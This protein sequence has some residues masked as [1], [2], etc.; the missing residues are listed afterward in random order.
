MLQIIVVKDDELHSIEAF[1]LEF[2]YHLTKRLSSGRYVVKGGCN[3]RFFFASA[4]FSEDIEIDADTSIRKEALEA[5]VRKILSSPSFVLA[6]AARRLRILSISGPE[7]DGASLKW[8]IALRKGR[9]VL[10]T[11]I[12]FLKT[13]SEPGAVAETVAPYIVVAH[14]IPPLVLPHYAVDTAIEQKMRALA[15]RSL[16]QARDVFDLAFL[17]IKRGRPLELASELATAAKRNLSSI[18]YSDFTE[19]VLPFLDSSIRCGFSSES[20]WERMRK[21]VEEGLST[22]GR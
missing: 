20:A 2:L 9:S 19:N 12:E 1:H 5:K 14:N 13:G 11:G 6:L 22:E 4:R 3:L 17:L 18:R 15:G 8:K 10:R 21:Q 16:P 7:E